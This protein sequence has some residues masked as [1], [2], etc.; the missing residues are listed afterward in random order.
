MRPFMKTRSRR[1]ALLTLALLLPLLSCGT[2]TDGAPEPEEPMV[3]PDCDALV[4]QQCGFPFPS[5]HFT[6][7]D[8]TSPTGKRV[9]FG[10]STL[11]VIA[12]LKRPID[13]AGF[14]DS[15]GFSPGHAPLTY[16]P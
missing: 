15:D 2:H 14:A 11:P 4:P 5:D 6:R 3:G 7:A 8:S 12:A 10:R 1:Y 13:P 16:L 9:A